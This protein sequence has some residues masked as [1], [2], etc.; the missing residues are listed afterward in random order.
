MTVKTTAVVLAVLVAVAAAG[1]LVFPHHH[2]VFP[3][4]RVP[5]FQAA[6]GIVASMALVFVPKALGRLLQSPEDPR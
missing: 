1:D 2:P 3:W 4:H 5:G 6:L